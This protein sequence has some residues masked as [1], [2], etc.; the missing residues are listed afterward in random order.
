MSCVNPCN[1]LI[2]QPTSTSCKKVQGDQLNLVLY[3]VPPDCNN[4]LHVSANRTSTGIFYVRQWPKS[5]QLVFLS[6]LYYSLNP[7]LF[8]RPLITWMLIAIYRTTILSVR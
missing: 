7:S 2:K 3:S 5:R 6:V 8:I 1:Q 4:T